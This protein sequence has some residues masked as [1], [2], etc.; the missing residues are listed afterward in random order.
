VS[1]TI[2]I[3]III[4]I[5]VVTALQWSW[6]TR[7][8]PLAIGIPA[9]LMSLYQVIVEFKRSRQRE[10][11][12][13]APPPQIMDIALDQ[14]IPKEVVTRRTAIALAWIFSLVLAI[15]LA[16]FLIAT[17][18]FVFFYLRYEARATYPMAV[19]VAAVTLLFIWGL[20]DQIL[21]TAWPDAV[22]FR[23]LGD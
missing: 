3:T 10:G 22:I 2:F 20:F 15:W 4:A 17:P 9:L 7:L 11:V 23:I 12:E 13:Q 18:L 16:G 14:S 21:H 5:A 1:L 8:F 19:L 6:D